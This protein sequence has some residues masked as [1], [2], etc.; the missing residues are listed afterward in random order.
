[1]KGAKSSAMRDP[2]MGPGGQIFPGPGKGACKLWPIYAAVP[3]TKPSPQKA[4]RMLPCWVWG[5]GRF[6]SAPEWLALPAGTGLHRHVGVHLQNHIPVLI[7]EED[8]Q[9]VHLVGNTARLWDA[10]DDAHGP[11]DALDGGVVGRAHDLQGRKGAWSQGA[12][13]SPT[14]CATCMSLTGAAEKVST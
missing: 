6:P 2:R 10:R 12:L 14:H 13:P 9:R 4:L 1:M 3:L 11:D 7:Q 8:P 5:G